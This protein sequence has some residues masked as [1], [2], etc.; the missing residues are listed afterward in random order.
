MPKAFS[1]KLFDDAIT[2]RGRHSEEEPKA[3]EEGAVAGPTVKWQ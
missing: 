3:N 2:P 1:G